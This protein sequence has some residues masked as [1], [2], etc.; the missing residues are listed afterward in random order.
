MGHY[1]FFIAFTVLFSM[2]VQ[3]DVVLM[4]S[5]EAKYN[6]G[7]KYLKFNEKLSQCGNFKYRDIEITDPWFFSLKEADKK[8]VLSTLF[9]QS[10][11]LC[12]KK[13]RDEY[14]LSLLDYTLISGDREGIDEWLS[15]YQSGYIDADVRDTVNKLDPIKLNN[16]IN[17]D[18]FSRPFDIF[19]VQDT[20]LKN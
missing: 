16:F 5:E 2:S 1:K 4:T 11:Y 15:L 10:R 9:Y 12:S 7:A 14:V 3:A 19:K 20:Y 17:Q 8:A 13:E 18:K 6:A